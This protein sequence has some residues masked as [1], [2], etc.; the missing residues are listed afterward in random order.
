MSPNKVGVTALHIFLMVA[1]RLS[2]NWGVVLSRGEP[3]L[4]H[5]SE[6]FDG[7]EVSRSLLR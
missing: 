5:T 7:N 1:T 6:D 2:V 3:N 4:E